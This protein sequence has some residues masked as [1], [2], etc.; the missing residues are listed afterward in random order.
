MSP[1]SHFAAGLF[2]PL[3]TMKN[4]IASSALFSLLLP[5]QAELVAYF[6]LNDGNPGEVAEVI[7]DIIDNPD[8]AVTDG[9]ANNQSATWVDDAERG[10]VLDSPGNNRFL[11]GTQDIDLTKGFTWS[12]WAKVVVGET[13]PKVVIGTRNGQWHKITVSSGVDGVGFVDFANGTYDLADGEWHHIA[14]VGTD[15]GSGVQNDVDVSLYL[16][17][18]KLGTDTTAATLN[19]NGQMEIGGSTRFSEY[20]NCRLDDVAIWDEALSEETIIGLANGDPIVPG[21]G[22]GGGDL[23]VTSIS[24]DSGADAV[25]LTWRANTNSTYRV[26][27]ST[28]LNDWSNEVASGVDSTTDED[29]SDE[30]FFTKTVALGGTGLAGSPKLFFRVE[31]D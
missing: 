22:G 25:T 26:F 21:I 10:V 4:T 7:D 1:R 27:A 12:L 15:N 8:H 29:Q 20:A 9:T 24:Y 2:L 28:D 31:E 23:E 5:C 30:G 19:Y 16:D 13:A 17:G 11:A 3:Q 14:L 6:P 18:V